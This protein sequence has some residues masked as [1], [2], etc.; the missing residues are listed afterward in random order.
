MTIWMIIWSSADHLFMPVENTM[1]LH[2]SHKGKQGR[3]LGQLSG[4]RNLAMIFGSAIAWFC[5]SRID[6]HLYAWLY[7]AAAC[8]AL[9]SVAAFA[10]VHVGLDTKARNRRFVLRREYRTF[11]WLN[12]LFGARKQVFLT[13]APW[14][15]VTMYGAKPSTMAVLMFVASCLGVIFRQVFGIFVDKFGERAMFIAD[16]VILLAICAGF[17]FS[18]NLYLLYTLYILDNLMFAT[19]IARTTYL[20]RIARDKQD[21]PATLS[22]GI[23][24]DHLVSMTV[25]FFGG[26]LWKTCGYSSVFMAAALLA[27][28]GFF[29]ACT[30]KPRVNIN[31]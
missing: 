22:M 7:A 28:A 23:T 13:F 29:V 26:L 21:I 8:A 25:P 10:K 11:Y 24:M 1:G 16:A 9:A 15:L 3:R 2:F 4:A 19:R 18:N 6:I 27:V 30:L 5:A 20:N 14:V 17:G 12:I 31:A